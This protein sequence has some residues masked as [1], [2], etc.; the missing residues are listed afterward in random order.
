MSYLSHMHPCGWIMGRLMIGEGLVVTKTFE[1]LF[2][3][4]FSDIHMF[5][6]DMSFDPDT[7]AQ[8]FLTDRTLKC[9]LAE[10][11]PAHILPFFS[12]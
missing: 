6:P 9:P 4:K 11:L 10:L 5:G 7:R 8:G 1:T 3:L 12:A 2:A